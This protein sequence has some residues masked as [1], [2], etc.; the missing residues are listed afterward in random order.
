[1]I[2]ILAVI[3]LIFLSFLSTAQNKYADSLQLALTTTSRP[4]ERFDLLNKLIDFND[5]TQGN[6]Q[7]TSIGLQMHRLAQQLQND[8]L[9]AIST[10]V[11]GNYFRG[12]GDFPVALEYFFKA[13]PLAEKV[14][15]K[16]F[17]L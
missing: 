1:M 5:G 4:T 10:N 16:R 2:K 3:L 17:F 8:S 14:N 15:D 7:D 11:V 6:F 12:K 13:I 9:L